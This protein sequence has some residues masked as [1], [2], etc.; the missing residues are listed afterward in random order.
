[1]NRTEPNVIRRVLAIFINSHPKALSIKDIANQT[2]LKYDSIK[3][4]IRRLY[5][6]G[7]L[8]KIKRGYYKLLNKDEAILH[9]SN[10]RFR[11][12]LIPKVCEPFHTAAQKSNTGSVVN[13]TN[14]GYNSLRGW[15]E[16]FLDL[17]TAVFEVGRVKFRVKRSIGEKLRDGCSVNVRDKAGQVTYRLKGLTIIV[18]KYGSVRLYLKDP[19]S[20][21]NEFI[22]FLKGKGLSDVEVKYVLK[23]LLNSVPR[24]HAS[25][26]IPVTYDALRIFKDWRI[27]TRVLGVRVGDRVVV[28]RICGSHFPLEV[29][30]SGDLDLV[31]NFLSALMGVQHFSVLE[32]LQVYELNEINRK[33]EL[34][35]KGFSDLAKTLKDLTKRK[36]ELESSLTSQKASPQG[37][38]RYVT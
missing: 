37:E 26:E 20:W 25:V 10:K 34:V 28:S 24:A 5:Q 7:F 30:V 2:N 33:F 36:V 17:S 31:C 8:I 4:A 35:A 18:S 21:F 19:A 15:F 16:Q 22:S 13:S 6:K 29:E 3:T 23:Q 38:L 9:L 1:M 12:R 27:E 11:K 32:F 14:N